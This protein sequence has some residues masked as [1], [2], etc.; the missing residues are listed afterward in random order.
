[1]VGLGKGSEV[2]ANPIPYSNTCRMRWV[3]GLGVRR[4]FKPIPRYLIPI[5]VRW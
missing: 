2:K 1:M 5:H 3:V 4:E